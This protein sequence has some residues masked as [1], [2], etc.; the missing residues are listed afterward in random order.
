MMNDMA[1]AVT[2]KV[3]PVNASAIGLPVKQTTAQVRGRTVPAGTTSLSILPAG[4]YTVAQSGTTTSQP[5]QTSSQREMEAHRAADKRARQPSKHGSA[6]SRSR[7]S[8]P[9]GIPLWRRARTACASCTP[10]TFCRSPAPDS[11]RSPSRFTCRLLRRI[12]TSW[13]RRALERRHRHRA[14]PAE[15]SRNGESTRLHLARRRYAESVV[16]IRVRWQK[17]RGSTVLSFN[18]V[19]YSNANIAGGGSGIIPALSSAGYDAAWKTFET[20][21]SGLP[22]VGGSGNDLMLM[23]VTLKNGWLMDHVIFTPLPQASPVGCVHR[24]A[25]SEHV[26]RAGDGPLGGSTPSV[27]C[28][29]RCRSWQS[30]KPTRRRMSR[31]IPR[32][33]WLA[34]PDVC[35]ADRRSL[36]FIRA[37][38]PP[39][40]LG[41]IAKGEWPDCHTHES[42]HFDTNLGEDAAQLAI[43][44]LVEHDLE[45]RATARARAKQRD[46]FHL[47][48]LA[49]RFRWG[50]APRASLSAR[51]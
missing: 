10:A 45:P 17:T 19:C 31:A 34:C 8:T 12:S 28:R 14:D 27:R 30:G 36:H 40:A 43:L 25:A 15:S 29:I 42:Q 50:L 35:S 11:A 48:Q 20:S 32:A 23:G 51:S 33:N 49:R 21:R 46:R 4:S 47:E 7:A 5:G 9:A 37:K 38:S 44:S 24:R 41:E 26:E 39:R 16:G 6:Q 18:P 13:P 2:A 1:K 22:G 3:G